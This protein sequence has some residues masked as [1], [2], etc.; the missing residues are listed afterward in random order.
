MFKKAIALLKMERKG[1]GKRLQSRLF[2]F[3]AFAGAFI[4]MM[5]VL[6]L[7]FGIPDSGRHA[8]RTFME[9]ELGRINRDIN[10]DF[11]KLAAEGI[12]FAD[13]SADA[14]GQLFEEH[15][16]QGVDFRRHPELIE[17][18]LTA[19]TPRMLELMDRLSCSGVYI[20]L[21][22]TVNPDI[23]GAQNSRAGVFLK[24]TTV[25]AVSSMSKIYC[26]RGSAE[27]AR[28]NGIELLGQWRMEF[29][30]KGEEF[31]GTVMSNA[32]KNADAK[33]SR[34]YCW[35]NRI[36]LKDNSE[37]G[38]LLCVP[39][40]SAGRVYGVFGIEVSD[41]FFKRMY[42]P[43][44]SE[45]P[46]IFIAAAP[47]DGSKFFIDK[48]MIAG[49]YYLTGSHMHA[50]LNVISVHSGFNVYDDGT[51]AYGG[52]SAEIKLYPDDS[53]YSGQ[54]WITAVLINE[55]ELQK[56]INGSTGYLIAI[57]AVL[58]VLS[59]GMSVFI[60]KKYL[61][62]VTDGLNAIKNKSFTEAE[63][64]YV[65]INDLAQSL[66]AMEEKVTNGG[67]TNPLL[68]QFLRNAETLSPAEL[69]VFKLY[70]KGC[71]AQEIADELFLSI[72]TIKTHSR[73]I[74]SKLGVT[75]RKE[76]MVYVRMM[77]EAGMI[78]GVR[79]DE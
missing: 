77:E 28:Q 16:Y 57:A 25:G 12:Y 37:S 70:L 54:E 8:V 27:I 2:A 43:G 23:D 68:E 4:I 29:D 73:R 19:Q 75:S 39:M 64:K 18:F 20:M 26:L 41:R 72:N 35:T 32:E 42:S 13:V 46:G 76:L 45:Y 78:S 67:D 15:G 5:F 61:E 65:E 55:T 33:L 56:L 14:A 47:A 44:S 40:I 50:P 63:N 48:G 79:H 74:F 60:S 24:K 34:L 17:E 38:F 36:T 3:F 22:A 49:N 1:K 52:L 10:Q 71:K 66:A 59:L 58:L 11:G 6:L 30:I 51:N 31:F 7:L 69:S 21:D 53:V 9:S 62:P